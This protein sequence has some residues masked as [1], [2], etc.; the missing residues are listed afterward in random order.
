MI[1][2]IIA[3]DKTITVDGKGLNCDFNMDSNTWAIQWGGSSGHTEFRDGTPNEEFT[4]VSVIQGYLDAYEAKN[5]QM[6]QNK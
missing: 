2:S 6:Q 5:R 3:D 1:V 4:E